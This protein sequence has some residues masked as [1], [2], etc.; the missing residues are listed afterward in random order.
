M[1]ITV[2]LPV[3]LYRV[4]DY[5]P[6]PSISSTTNNKII[7]EIP[8]IGT[9]VQVPFGRQ[10]LIG[11]VVAH[12][13]PKDSQ[14]PTNKLKTIKKVIDTNPIVSKGLL[15]LA[16]WLANYYHYPLGDTISVMLPTFVREDKEL[17]TATPH[18]RT[19][20]EI[21]KQENTKKTETDLNTIP[22]GISSRATK[23]IQHYQT[24][25][26]FGEDGIA[27]AQ[28]SNHSLS[29]PYLQKL[30]D[31]QLVERFIQTA[32]QPKKVVVNE[33][34]L[35]LNSE[36]TYA[37]NKITDAYQQN[38]Y[39]GFLLNGITGS[40]KTEVYLQAM[41]AV[42]TAG[43]QVLVLVPEIGLTPQ[44]KARFTERFNANILLLHSGLNNTQ[45][46]K[47]WLNCREG[48]AQII[49]G[50]RSTL[51]YPFAN[52]GLIIVDEAHDGSYKQQDSLRYRTDDVAL[53]RG[54]QDS[55]PVVLGTATPNLEHI[56]LVEDCKLIELKLTK[57]AG[58]AIPPQ[59]FIE[60]TRNNATNHIN[61]TDGSR[62]DVGL[63]T[64]VINS[65]RKH[66]QAGEQVLIH[67]N[68]R[69]YAPVIICDACGWQADCPRCSA[70]L[71]LHKSGHQH[72]QH[73]HLSCHH[74]GWQS[75]VP[76]HCPD[77]G[78]N[79]IQPVGMGTSRLTQNLQAL[80]ANP[81]TSKQIY[82]I[83][84][85]DR[86]TTRKK[87]SWTQIYNTINSGKP[88][89]LVGTQMIAKGHHFPNVTLVVI[90]NADNGFLSA[91]IRSPERTA[92]LIMQV[93]G[94]AGR[95]EKAGKVII[96]TKQP[97]N[98]L[99]VKLIKEGYQPFAMQLLKD[100]KLM[101]LPPY[102]HSAL[103]RCEGKNQAQTIATLNQAKTLLPNGHQL[104]VIGAMESPMPKKNSR[105]HAQ[106]LLLAKNRSHLHQV[107][108]NWW[109]TVRDLPTAKYQK[110]TLD[111]DPI[112]W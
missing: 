62:E 22:A 106:L 76:K 83:I 73:S 95:G 42:L 23:Q 51:L 47:G 63:T 59:F 36:Q 9:R 112:S 60:D 102:T 46:L 88:A 7:K 87:D 108:N 29:K 70:H 79:N 11:L 96:Q 56:K 99:L 82:P 44:T 14:I 26:R 31:K 21:N 43:K 1:L 80:F 81:Q 110:L 52:L 35:T 65:I 89:I 30:A 24:L 85:I 17:T 64:N 41:Q 16:N 111:I 20:T 38:T 32:K 13:D 105:Y 68:R 94:R 58:I 78:S 109:L 49:I 18:W 3:P 97:E 37:V 39:K 27:E 100:R 19:L 93:S 71:T 74:C 98:P 101:G 53:Y 69:G 67:I 4:F 15:A 12:K 77:C 50:T 55:I 57:R 86:D 75:Y 54:Y 10:T 91:D 66:L 72:Q 5:L 90:P 84:Q 61:Q 45:R 104:A 34:P 48:Q 2:A 107:I 40:G 25:L 8:A 6:A 28:L 33:K 92:Q 103:I